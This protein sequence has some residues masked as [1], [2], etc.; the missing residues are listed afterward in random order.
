MRLKPFPTATSQRPSTGSSPTGE[1]CWT[2]SYFDCWWIWLI[3]VLI[4]IIVSFREINN[5]L[6]I[7]I[8]NYPLYS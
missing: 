2:D 8:D 6:F 5:Y 3:I 4:I 7:D 1:K